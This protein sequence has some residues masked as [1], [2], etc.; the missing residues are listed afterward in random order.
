MPA[1]F[2]AS[3]PNYVL[4]AALREHMVTPFHLTGIVA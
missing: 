3:N 4:M 1:L 2:A